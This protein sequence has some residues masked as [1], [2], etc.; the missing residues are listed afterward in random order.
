MVTAMVMATAME[1][2]VLRVVLQGVK[3]RQLLRQRGQAS[4]VVTEQGKVSGLQ[5]PVSSAVP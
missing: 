3:A 5:E 4:L 1:A 2:G